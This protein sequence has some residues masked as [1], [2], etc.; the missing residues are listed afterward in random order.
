MA[1]RPS[2]AF[3][4]LSHPQVRQPGGPQ[5]WLVSSG[6]EDYFLGTFYFDKGADIQFALVK[7]W[8]CCFVFVTP[9]RVSCLYGM[10]LGFAYAR[11][12]LATL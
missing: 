11:K 12:L 9:V 5:S 10:E 3:D 2:I 6:T 7:E 1:I 8:A 4:W